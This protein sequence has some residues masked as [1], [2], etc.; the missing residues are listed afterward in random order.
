LVYGLIFG[1]GIYYI[2]RLI[3]RGPQDAG[4]EPV[5][6]AVAPWQ[7]SPGVASGRKI[8]AETES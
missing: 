2:N 1:M 3:E 8:L 7:L 4:V 5:G 6:V